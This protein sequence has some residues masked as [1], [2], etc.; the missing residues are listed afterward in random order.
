MNLT[1]ADAAGADIIYSPNLSTITLGN[2][3]SDGGGVARNNTDHICYAW[4]SVEN[5][6]KFGSY[7]GNGSADGPFVYCGFRPAFVMVKNT[8]ITSTFSS[9]V[10][11]DNARTPNNPCSQ[12][13]HAD[14][15][16][17]EGKRTTGTAFSVADSSLDFLSNGFVPRTNYLEVN[18]INDTFVYAA[19]GEQ[20]FNY[21]NAR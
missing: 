21:A 5:Y 9:W 16:T 13:L 7:I 2:G 10:I 15:S 17:E 14:S 6:S 18:S 19:F 1:D 11:Y 4:H 12:P 8:T 3:T 20:P